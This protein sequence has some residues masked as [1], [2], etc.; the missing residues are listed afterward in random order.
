M[1]EIIKSLVLTCGIIHRPARR[2]AHCE[3]RHAD[4]CMRRGDV[5]KTEN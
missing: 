4:Q 2:E 3:R 5:G 1:K